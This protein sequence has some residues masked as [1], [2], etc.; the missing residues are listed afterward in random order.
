ME[1]ESQKFIIIVADAGVIAAT[2]IAHLNLESIKNEFGH[3]FNTL[4]IINNAAEEISIT[5]DG[6]KV[7]YLSGGGGIFQI[8]W[9]DGIIFDDVQLT[10]EDA[11]AATSANEIRVSVGRTGK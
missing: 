11:A 1:Q 8:D 3:N 9:E 6:R 5:L 7:Q 4:N 10:N 2:A